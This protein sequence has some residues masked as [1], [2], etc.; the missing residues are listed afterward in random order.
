MTDV[1]N[2]GLE[3]K[4][5]RCTHVEYAQKLKTKQKKKT[6]ALLKYHQLHSGLDYWC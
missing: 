6:F 3:E 4:L 2:V 1:G 5:L